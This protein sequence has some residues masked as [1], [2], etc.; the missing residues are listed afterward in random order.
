MKKRVYSF[1]LVLLMIFTLIGCVDLRAQYPYQSPHSYE[2]LR[3]QTIADVI[4]AVVAVKTETGHGSGVIFRKETLPKDQNGNG[5]GTVE[6]TYL[7]Y[8]I[9]NHHVVEDGGEMSIYFG[10]QIQEIKAKDV[11]IYPLYDLAV[12]RFES[13]QEFQFIDSVA[14]NDNLFVEKMIGQDVIAIGTP[15]EISLFNYVTL[16]VLSK[17]NVTYNG[18]PSLTIMHNA[19]L[20]PGNSGGPLFNLNGELIGINVAK[21]ATIQQSNGQMPAEGLNYSLDINKLAT[22]IRNFKEADYQVIERRPRLGV[23]VQDVTVFL[24]PEQGNEP[25][26]VPADTLG[27]VVIGLDP[28]R[29]AYGKLE[30]YDLIIEMNGVRVESIADISAQLDGAEF[31]DV[32]TVKV[33]RKIGETFEEVTVTITLS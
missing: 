33:L 5:N 24:D 17:K 3:I 8:V 6:D 19:E 16:G 18:V 1:I 13:Q 20:N 26:L 11:A 31:G 2:E 14:I 23:T 29:D 25:S 7:Y 9:T 27:V 32:H 4:D 12:V 30:V 28:T 15:R 21:I 10:P 22:I